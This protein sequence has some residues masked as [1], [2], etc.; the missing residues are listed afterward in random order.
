MYEFVF[1]HLFPGCTT[2]VSGDSREEVHEK[3]RRHVRDRHLLEGIDKGFD[4]RIGVA[5]RRLEL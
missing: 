1:E 3:A 4:D 2:N 5:I